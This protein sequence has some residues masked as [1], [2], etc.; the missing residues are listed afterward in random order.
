[1]L[2][3]QVRIGIAERRRPDFAIYVPVQ[4]WRFKWLVAE[5]DGAHPKW[6]GQDD[7]SRDRS[8]EENRYEVI[9]LRPG[10]KGYLEEVRSLAER[11]EVLMAMSRTDE[12]DVAIEA[13]VTSFDEASPFLKW[14]PN[15]S[16]IT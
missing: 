3:P 1:M 5:L 2:I 12:W 9:S 10:A 16:R 6:K 13:Q 7:A 14:M 15:A 4:Y 11:V 8:I